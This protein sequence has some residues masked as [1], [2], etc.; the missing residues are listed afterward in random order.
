MNND[1][2][3]EKIT[4]KDDIK[5]LRS[6]IL[7]SQKARIDLLKFK[8]IAIATLGAIGL[9]FGEHVTNPRIDPDVILCIIPFVCVYIDLL[10]YHNTMRILVIAQFLNYS[11]DLYENYISVLG[12]YNNH[13]KKKVGYY[14]ELEDFSLY[15]SS[16]MLSGL[17]A[18]Y[19]FIFLYFPNLLH[20][21]KTNTGY[22]L[23]FIG[24]MGIACTFFYKNV[25]EKHKQN[26]FKTAG[27]LPGNLSISGSPQ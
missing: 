13:H 17:L 4:A 8:L 10:C 1:G 18:C 12:E 22:I 21:V 14:F 7:E 2:N 24:V 27:N 26:L 6:E 23:F 25:Y 5:S 3:N 11:G 15:G 9:G 20:E 16:I 19:G